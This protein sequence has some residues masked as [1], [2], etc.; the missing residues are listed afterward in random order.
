MA[1]ISITAA[2]VVPSAQAVVNN[3]LLAGAAITAGQAVYADSSNTWQL[4]DADLSATA[5]QCHGIA[6]NNAAAGQPLSVCTEDMTGLTL[7]GTVA[8][9]D[10]IYTSP[11]AGGV[12]KTQADL[13]TG[14]Y[15]T[16]LGVAISA[17]KIKLKII[18]SG[19]A[20][21]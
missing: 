11:T 5:A 16:V 18:P 3:S 19:V 14:V 4:T 1:A 7:G 9:G 12:T 8:A 21:A 6:L 20:H 17:T 10:T 15:T 2:N 13:V